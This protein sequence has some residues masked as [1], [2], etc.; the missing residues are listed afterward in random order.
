VT[1][2]YTY[3]GAALT[4]KVAP[5][6]IDI[7]QRAD[8]G[9]VSMG[10][11]PIEDPA[12]DLTMLGH[13][14]FTVT[15][16][17]CAQPRLFTGWTAERGIGRSLDLGLFVGPSPRVH[18]AT[19][20]D[21]NALFGF[22]L[23]SGADAKRPEET[24]EARLDWILNSDYLS[25]LI[26]SSRTFTDTWPNPMDEADYTGSFPSAVLDDL[27]QRF[28]GAVNYFA[29]WDPVGAAVT[30]FFDHQDQ[31]IADCALS[32]S[33]LIADVNSTTCFAP[34]SVS[35]LQRE[36]DQTYS[37]VIVEYAN[38]KVFRTAPAT[39]TKFIRRGTT[40]SRPYTG[41]KATAEAQGDEF[42][43][44]HSEEVDRITCTF[45]V[46]AA[47]VGLVRA[48]QRIQVKFSHMP[49]YAAFTWM[50]IVACSPK[51]ID[52]LAAYYD[53]ELEL[54]GPHPADAIPMF[55]LAYGHG[56]GFYG[57]ESRA[58]WPDGAWIV[59]WR[60]NGDDDPPI[61]GNPPAASPTS[62]PITFIAFAEGGEAFPYRGIKVGPAGVVDVIHYGRF[63]GVAETGCSITVAIRQNGTVISTQTQNHTG[64]LGYWGG[65]FSFS[66]PDVTVAAGDE[67][68]VSAYMPGWAGFEYYAITAGDTV[69]ESHLTV[70]GTGTGVPTTGTDLGPIPGVPTLATTDP[71]VNDDYAAGYTVGSVWINTTTGEVFVLVDATTGA[72]VWI[73]VTDF[74]PT[75][76][77]YLVGTATS[78]L[79]AEIV[80]GPTPGGELGG[81]WASP[82]VDA[83]HSGSAHLA[84]GT[85]SST[86]AA[87]NHGHAA[88]RGELLITDT[89]AGS[90]LIFADIL[91][92]D[93]GTDLLYADP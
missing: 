57:P 93:A 24:W 47:S 59:G 17:A 51:P 25:G 20:I 16:S 92:N 69:T 28:D 11:I 40:I 80:V 46:P 56:A 44:S 63:G 65:Y 14:P 52:D 41:K 72:A 5:S 26:S 35:R 34:D 6:G 58:T 23:V 70:S 67:F 62:G 73:S 88:Y 9:E 3:D 82:T 22:R 38:G 1:L 31:G 66:L 85:T 79:S 45:R 54:V 48:G 68:G 60:S 37:E 71:T 32:I 83:T 55:A 30:L 77:D 15:E 21:L 12:A 87:G 74:A 84:L 64:G 43:A 13:R 33:N 75:G 42:L 10:G 36:P 61:G 91:Q 90:P 7:P 49:G 81:T 78:A 29:F 8:M 76:V 39:A 2:A 4:H 53:V 18:D 19:I 89:P 27:A 86:A 50:R